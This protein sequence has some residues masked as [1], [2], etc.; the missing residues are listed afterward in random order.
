MLIFT[1]NFIWSLL[2]P[3]IPIW[4]T[5]RIYKDF[6]NKKRIFERYGVSRIERPKGKLIWV[7]ASSLGESVSASAMAIGLAGLFIESHPDPDMA[8]CD[9]PSA[10]PLGLLEPFL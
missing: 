1:Y 3:L 9:G 6:E 5:Y 8:L 10:L 7:H 4:L 2:S